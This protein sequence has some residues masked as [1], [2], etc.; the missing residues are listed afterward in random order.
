MKID[1]SV[2]YRVC[3]AASQIPDDGSVIAQGARLQVMTTL[4]GLKA[5]ISSSDRELQR[6]CARADVRILTRM[7]LNK[8][9]FDK[10]EVTQFSYHL[11]IS[12]CIHFYVFLL[13]TFW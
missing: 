4:Q 9:Y 3:A 5:F 7:L 13:L 1:S 8:S 6:P 10:T 11:K 12:K 2:Y